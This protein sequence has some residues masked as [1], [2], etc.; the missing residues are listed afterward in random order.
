MK[1]NKKVRKKERKHA[2]DQEKK[3]VVFFLDAFLVES[4]FS[5][6]FQVEKSKI[7]NLLFFLVVSV[8]FFTF[9]L[10]RNRAFFVFSPC[11]NWLTRCKCH[12]FH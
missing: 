8:Y 11:K 3:R 6:L 1:E 9:F 10:V 12:D 2:V 5:F 7:I 4:V